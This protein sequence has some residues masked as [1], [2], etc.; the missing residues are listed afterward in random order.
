MTLHKNARL[1]PH[2]KVDI[3]NKHY[4]FHVRITTLAHEYHV[5]RVTIY[6]VL[7][8][9]RA[10]QLAP[11]KSVN[12]RYRSLKYGLKRLAKV[13]VELEKQLKSQAKRYNKVYPGEMMHVDTVRLPM[14]TGELRQTHTHEYLFVGIDDYSRELYAAIMPDKTSISS[15]AFLSQMLDECSYSI[16]CVYS[17]NGTE[18]KGKIDEH[19]F[20]LTCMVNGITQRFTKVKCPQ[21]NGKA[22][23]VIRTILEMWHQKEHFISRE[24][25]RL[26][27]N[28]F[29]NYYNTVKPHSALNGKTPYETLYAYFYQGAQTDIVINSETVNNA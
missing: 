21:T 12:K 17:D 18:Y 22:E 10:K 23:R 24:Q 15:Q 20:A 14:L 9:I 1:L 2:Q 25:R 4:Q 16:E 28:R 19:L 7:R 27:L 26:S 11:L 29:I 3:F 13:E 6:K 8:Q 5:S